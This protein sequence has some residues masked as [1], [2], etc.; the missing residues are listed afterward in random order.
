M[1]KKPS[2]LAQALRELRQW[3]AGDIMFLSKAH[4]D[5]KRVGR[6]R[7]LGSGVILSITAL[8]G[9]DLVEPVLIN[10][11]LSDETIEAL[12]RDVKRAYDYRLL[13]N[14]IPDDG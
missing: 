12:R 8:N 4:A 14:R 9:T 13:M 10:D 5:L 6:E 7:F 1:N 3:K 11:G 2:R